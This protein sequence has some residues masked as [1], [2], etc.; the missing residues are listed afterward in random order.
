MRRDSDVLRWESLGPRGC[1]SDWA[2][3]LFEDVDGTGDD[4]GGGGQ[5]DG[6]LSGSLAHLV[7]GMVSVGENAV[8]LV[9]LT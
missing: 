9:K 5:R 1:R 8:A 6:A 3:R 2:T 7:S 4:Q